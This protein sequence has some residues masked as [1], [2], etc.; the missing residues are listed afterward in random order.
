[1]SWIKQIRKKSGISKL[2]KLQKGKLRSKR[3]LTFDEARTVGVLFNATDP[4]SYDGV[5]KFI[6]HLSSRHIRVKVFGYCAGKTVPNIF[7]SDPVIRTFSTKEVDFSY[8][9][10]AY[11]CEEFTVSNFDILVNLDTSEELPLLVLST[12]ANATLK[13]GCSTKNISCYDLMLDVSPDKSIDYMVGQMNIYLNMFKNS[14][15][16]AV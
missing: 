5:R 3:L 1:V 2:K 9:P 13:I 14:A 7:L 12:L 16:K 10:S 11:I 6:T 15:S 8:F 4:A